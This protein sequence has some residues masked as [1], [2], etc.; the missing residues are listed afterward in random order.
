MSPGQSESVQEYLKRKQ[1]EL[2]RHQKLI[3]REV[4]DL[5]LFEEMREEIQVALTE[6]LALS[7]HAQAQI[8]L[9]QKM[10]HELTQKIVQIKKSSS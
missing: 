4:S 8:D 9:L 2:N 1:A 3:D 6:A 10:S 5:A 7:E